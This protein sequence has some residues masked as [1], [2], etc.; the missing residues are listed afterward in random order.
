MI[1]PERW[2]ALQPGNPVHRAE[3]LAKATAPPFISTSHESIDYGRGPWRR[4]LRGIR[5]A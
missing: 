5:R 1:T 4:V 2:S 3:E